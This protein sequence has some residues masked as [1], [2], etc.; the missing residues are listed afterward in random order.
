[1]KK[2]RRGPTLE[3]RKRWAPASSNPPQKPGHPPEKGDQVKTSIVGHPELQRLAHLPKESCATRHFQPTLRGHA[4]SIGRDRSTIR[5][6]DNPLSGAPT[7]I[8][9]K[10][11][12]P[13]PSTKVGW[14]ASKYHRPAKNRG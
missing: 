8:A 4:W 13:I 5:T 9:T 1:M 14:V 6:E 12:V 10:K 3:N 7:M 2:K 11:S